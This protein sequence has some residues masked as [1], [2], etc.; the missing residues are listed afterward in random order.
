VSNNAYRM[1]IPIENISE[2]QFELSVD[3]EL[4]KRV[5]NLDCFGPDDQVYTLHAESSKIAFGDGASGKI[6][7]TGSSIRA[8]Y[9]YGVGVEGNLGN[10]PTITLTW[11]SKS[12]RKNEIIGA[13]IESKAD[14]I[15]FW[16]CRET[17]VPHRWKWGVM[18][19][20]N[21]KRWALRLTCRFSRSR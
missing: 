12:F 6:P 18:L 11:T 2:P 10:G 13:L 5:A 4:W 20:R 16:T 3:G 8:R 19:C 14:G 9:R 15:I 17:E 21:I 1:K 7:L